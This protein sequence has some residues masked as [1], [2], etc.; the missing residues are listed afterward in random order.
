MR[1][2]RCR[3]SSL[4]EEFVKE[5]DLTLDR[6]PKCQGVWFDRGE[7]SRLLAEAAGEL[8]IPRN[9]VRLQSKCPRCDK[10]LYA[11]HYPRTRVTVE[12][13][14]RC[15]GFWL[16]QGEFSQIRKARE[17]LPQESQSDGQTDANSVKGAL[18]RFIDWALDGFMP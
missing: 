10:P 1:C 3:Q 5:K 18:I 15:T 16:D 6:C 12:M 11:F 4:K 14:K 13:C 7:L 17:S 8:E 2:P 9:A